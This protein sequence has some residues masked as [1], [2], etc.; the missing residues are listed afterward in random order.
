MSFEIEFRNILESRGLEAI[1]DNFMFFSVLNDS[2]RK[3]RIDV[4]KIKMFYMIN[5]YLNLYDLIS[6]QDLSIVFNAIQEF[7]NNNPYG[8]LPINVLL[9]LEPLMDFVNKDQYR[10]F[11]LPYIKNKQHNTVKLIKKK[12]KVICAEKELILNIKCPFADLVLSDNDNLVIFKPYTN[13]KKVISPKNKSSQTHIYNIS[14]KDEIK[15]QIPKKYVENINVNFQGSSIDILFYDS[16]RKPI[17]LKLNSNSV[18]T[19]INGKFNN[20][21]V[22]GNGSYYFCGFAINCNI[23]GFWSADIYIRNY[24]IKG[25]KSL[26]LQV[27]ASIV[28]ITSLYKFFPKIHTHLKRYYAIKDVYNF[29]NY[30]YDLDIKSHYKKIIIK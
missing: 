30:K 3:T 8:Y 4:A 15:I 14:S 18:T 26:S 22:Q 27:D 2:K 11:V 7:I 29:A 6:K 20:L 21:N 25:V 5:S 16:C 10:I 17:N 23:N 13:K 12:E 28:K 1:K 19:S 24:N 9:C